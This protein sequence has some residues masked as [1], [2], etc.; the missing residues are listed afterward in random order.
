MPCF[1]VSVIELSDE[2]IELIVGNFPIWI[3]IRFLQKLK[4]N[5]LFDF[6]TVSQ[7][8]SQLADLDLTTAV[9]IK[10]LKNL[11][12]IKLSDKEKPIR[13]VGHKLG[14]R[15]SIFAQSI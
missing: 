6:L 2:I 7:S 4:P 11:N 15:K 13:A 9:L 14:K 1:F 8:V 5:L 10:N 3:R 12:D